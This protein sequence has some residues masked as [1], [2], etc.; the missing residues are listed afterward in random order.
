MVRAFGREKGE[1]YERVSEGLPAVMFW[2]VV[3]TL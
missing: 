1:K 3:Q 2:G